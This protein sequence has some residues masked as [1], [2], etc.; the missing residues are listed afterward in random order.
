MKKVNGQWSMVNRKG[1][2][3]LKLIIISCI[4][5]ITKQAPAQT[6]SATLDR[7]KILLGEQVTLTLQV[8]DVNTRLTTLQWLNLPDTFNHIEIVKRDIIDSIDA[9]G[10][11]TFSQKLL[12]TSFDSGRWQF[13]ELK[14]T[15]TDNNNKQTVIK[16]PP[17]F[18]D[19]LPVD[20]SNLKDYHPIKDIIE[21]D[22]KKNIYLI[23]ALV[24]GGILLLFALWWFLFRKKKP[25]PVFVKPKD[26]L[27]NYQR[28]LKQID[29][30]QQQNSPAKEFYQR[31]DDIYRTYFDEEL[32]VKTLQNTTDELMM[33][34]K[35]YLP[36]EKI[37]T[38]FY[39]LIRLTAAVKF[40]KYLPEDT[41]KDDVQTVLATLAYINQ[42]RIKQ[43]A[44]RMV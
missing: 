19:V 15:L 36:D 41:R 3:I 8:Q 4:I 13:P 35:L 6:I 30:L 2:F 14:M 16:T 31:L 7:D 32:D 1:A 22:V 5:F 24:A 40:A 26:N 29:L 28:A 25:K 42:Y 11:T 39:Q 44:D 12:I 18:I 37:R 38:V 20:V 27:T 21:V 34:M 43:N 9:G 10:L 17:L 23:V 33:T